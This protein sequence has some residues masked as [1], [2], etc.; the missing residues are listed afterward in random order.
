MV[1]PTRK[2]RLKNRIKLMLKP[3]VLLGRS[4]RGG[5]TR[6]NPRQVLF[7]DAFFRQE[8]NWALM[9]ALAAYGKLKIIY[10]AETER[11]ADL[12]DNVVWCATRRQA[13]SLFYSSA[14]VFF[15]HFSLN[16][17]FAP[18]KGQT[19]V[20]L[21]HGTPLKDISMLREGVFKYRDSFSY[22]LA[23][24]DEVGGLIKRTFGCDD[25]QILTLGYPRNDWLS[26][27]RDALAAMGIDKSAYALTVMWM[28]TFR[29]SSVIGRADSDIGFPILNRENIREFDAFLKA[30]NILV[31]IKPHP[32]ADTE[33]FLSSGCAN[34]RLF[35]NSDL[36]ARGVQAYQ[37]L[38][39]CD[40]LLTDYS[41][42]YFDFL[43][44]GRPVVFAFDDYDSYKSRIGFFFE[45]PLSVMPGPKV[46]M[47][48]ELCGALDALRDGRDEYADARAEI[49]AR[50]NKYADY[51]HCARLIARLGIVNE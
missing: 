24:S 43:L 51:G 23:A 49:G 17:S 14:F 16:N 46:Y 10:Y 21:W 1:Q 8:S 37:L 12:P 22:V 20:N 33:A 3:L 27:G 19:V 36:A 7:I 45:D 2:S 9:E 31:L 18:G 44:T 35:T 28:P 48:S 38:S 25:R 47:L 11:P 29:K 26:P 50:F 42:V 40:A 5:L 30:R 32:A 4:I 6:K 34:I 41:S 13:V 39:C 15:T